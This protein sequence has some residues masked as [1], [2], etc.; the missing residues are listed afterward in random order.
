MPYPSPS[1]PSFYFRPPLVCTGQRETGRHSTHARRQAR[2]R[3]GR[4]PFSSPVRL[5]FFCSF[6]FA[7]RLLFHAP[8]EGLRVADPAGGRLPRSGR[9]STGG[10]GPA[11]AHRGVTATVDGATATVRV[12][13]TV[14]AATVAG[15]SIYWW[16]PPSPLPPSSPQPPPPPPLPVEGGQLLAPRL[17]RRGPVPPPSRWL[18]GMEGRAADGVRWAQRSRRGKFPPRTPRPLQ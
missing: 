9:V 12:L 14:A 3:G 5:F 7:L 17:A 11:R 13:V 6:F 18:G 1:P 10:G 15:H 2:D 4:R 8:R 16:P